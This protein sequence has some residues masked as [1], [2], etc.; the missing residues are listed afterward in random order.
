M[1]SVGRT[2]IGME[3]YVSASVVRRLVTVPDVAL[4]VSVRGLPAL[5]SDVYKEPDLRVWLSTSYCIKGVHLCMW[6]VKK[7]L[8]SENSDWLPIC[9]VCDN[10]L[11]L[12]SEN[13][14]KNLLVEDEHPVNGVW[15]EHHVCLFV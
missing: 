1:G 12:P 4:M 7:K 13:L 11:W 10:F 9:D 6:N 8:F 3:M 2:W 5:I 15:L 14:V